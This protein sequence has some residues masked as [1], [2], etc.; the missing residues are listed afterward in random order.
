MAPQNIPSATV[1]T[2][3]NKVALISTSTV[4]VTAG[5]WGVGVGGGEWLRLNKL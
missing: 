3:D 5:R 4:S 1:F 2:V